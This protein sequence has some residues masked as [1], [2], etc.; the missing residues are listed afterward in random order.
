MLARAVQTANARST[1]P[2]KRNARPVLKKIRSMPHLSTHA[3]GLL[4]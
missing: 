4:A 2:R 1:P 3:V